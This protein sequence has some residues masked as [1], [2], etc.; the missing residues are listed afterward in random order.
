LTRKASSAIFTHIEI[1]YAVGILESSSLD[2]V[3]T[4]TLLDGLRDTENAEAWRRFEDRYGPVVQAFALKLGV[5]ESDVADVTQDTMM[6]FL[7]AYRLG[8]YDP[9]KGRLR[10]WLFSIAQHRILEFWRRKPR[11]VPLADQ[12]HAT[13]ILDH[14][15]AQP[16]PEEIWEQEW[17]VAILRACLAEV[18]RQVR[19]ETMQAFDLYVLQAWPV[20]RVA[21]HLGMTN[22]AVY[23]AKNRVMS[24]IRELRKLMEETF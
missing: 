22:N 23:L 1:A 6:A 9:T 16:T 3:T 20:S 15:G 2:T 8:G 11:E 7:E 12:T 13:A 21:E 4:L 5:S 24:R 14:V 19:P 18:S 10:S 17:Q